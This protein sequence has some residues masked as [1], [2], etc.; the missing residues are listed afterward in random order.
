MLLL[1]QD[2]K[3]LIKS[4]RLSC[5][6]GIGSKI[7]T[8]ITGIYLAV[9]CSHLNHLWSGRINYGYNMKFNIVL[10]NKNIIEIN[11]NN[12]LLFN[13]IKLIT[14][15]RIPNIHHHNDMVVQELQKTTSCAFSRM[16]YCPHSLCDFIRSC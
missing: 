5:K 2:R 11:K 13:Y 4:Y 8:L 14:L 6:D 12:R 7:F 10:G 1:I 16:V 9:L 3:S 15:N